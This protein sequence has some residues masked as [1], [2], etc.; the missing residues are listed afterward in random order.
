MSGYFSYCVPP[1]AENDRA[2]LERILVRYCIREDA[3]LSSFEASDAATA[4]VEL[5]R[6]GVH[7]EHQLGKIIGPRL[8]Y[9]R[10]LAQ[11]SQSK[12][13]ARSADQMPRQNAEPPDLV[14]D[15]TAPAMVSEPTIMCN[16]C[17]V[18]VQIDSRNDK[19]LRVHCPV[20]GNDF[21]KW[22]DFGP[23]ISGT[24][25]AADTGHESWRVLVN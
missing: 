24:A 18:A 22:S 8:A 7:N 5:F 17:D 12:H 14:T 21:G 19:V 11:P 2:M 9:L 15:K 16:R 23:A 6:H 4:L 25:E 3:V 10:Y 1:F 20:C 13:S